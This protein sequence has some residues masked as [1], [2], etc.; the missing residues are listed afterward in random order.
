MYSHTVPILRGMRRGSLL[1]GNIGTCPKVHKISLTSAKE[2]GNDVHFSSHM[3][4]P[5]VA[6]RELSFPWPKHCLMRAIKSL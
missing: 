4:F 6:L 2:R 3:I 1:I 5:I